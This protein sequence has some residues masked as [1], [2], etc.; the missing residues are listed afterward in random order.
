MELAVHLSWS[1]IQLIIVAIVN[2]I[3]WVWVLVRACK[4]TKER[5]F[6][7]ALSVV[8]AWI[9]WNIIITVL[10]FDVGHRQTDLNRSKFDATQSES[11]DK[12]E[13]NRVTVEDV[14]K[15]FEQSVKQ[16]EQ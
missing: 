13:S 3:F 4:T 2:M 1:P 11:I 6:R 7:K 5:K 14:K 16:T 8:T 10:A 15:S 12:V 9:V